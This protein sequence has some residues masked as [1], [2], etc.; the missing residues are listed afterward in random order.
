MY[1]YTSDIGKGAVLGPE[2]VYFYTATNAV[3]SNS[4]FYILNFSPNAFH[5]QQYR[6]SSLRYDSSPR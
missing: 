6:S 5:G 2:N 4:G 1:W 3:C